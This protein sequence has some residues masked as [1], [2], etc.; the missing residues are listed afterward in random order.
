MVTINGQQV[1][2]SDP[3]TTILQAARQAGIYIP[4][5]CAH[6]DLPP[7]GGRTP[8]DFIYMDGIRQET[9]SHDPVRGC[10]LCLVEADGERKPACK[11]PAASAAEVQT[12]TPAILAARRQNLAGILANHPHACLLCP[13]REGCDRVQCSLNVPAP[14]RCCAK[15]ASC[16]L[17]KVSEHVG[18]Q[19][20]TPR[21]VFAGLPVLRNQP[22]FTKDFN[23]CIHCTRCVRVCDDVRDVRSLAFIALNGRVVVG[24]VGPTLAESGCRFCTACVEVCP[25]GALM[26]RKPEVRGR[27]VA[28]LVTHGGR[29]HAL[30]PCRAACP[31]M[32][33]VPRYV[34]LVAE[35]RPSQAAAVIRERV[36]FPGVLGHVCFHPCE[37][38]CRRGAI[39]EPV[40]VC[41]LKRFAAERDGGVW[42]QRITRRPSTGKR[43][44]IV[45]S[46]PAG[47]TAAYFLARR[48]HAVTVLEAAPE[49]G[50]MLRYGIPEY[51]LPRAVL[52]R[53][54]REIANQGVVIATGTRVGV[55]LSL[56]QVRKSHDAVFVAVGAQLSRRIPVEGADL[57]G[58]L[59]GVDFLREAARRHLQQMGLGRTVVIGGGN[60][61]V[62]AAMTALRCGA[63]DAQIACLEK[64]EE[65]PA[66]DQEIAAMEEEGITIRNSWGP[67]AILG[68]GGGRVTGIE[69]KRC[70]SVFD[71]DHRF[72]P[73]YD[74]ATTTRLEC[75]TVILAI[76]Q[77]SDLTLL[78]G[79]LEPAAGGTIPLLEGET[80]ATGAPG[81]FAGGEAVS[82]PSSVVHAVAAGRK[83]AVEI[84]R[85][86]GGTGCLDEELADG[87]RGSARIG[88]DEGFA[89]RCRVTANR[90][91]AAERLTNFEV[92]D[93]G[94]DNGDAIAEAGRCL[95]C[96]LRLNIQAPLSPPVPWLPLNSD[97]IA[98]VP[99]SDGVYQLLDEARCVLRISGV[100]DL[101]AGLL[102]AQ[103][104][105]GKAK[106]FLY[107]VNRMY[108]QRESELLQHHLQEHGKMPEG[109]DEL[110]DLF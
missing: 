28:P 50:G 59:W 3:A 33:D 52:D 100:P 77:S 87:G 57:G 8:A 16:E 62:D 46:G 68:N 30:V 19:A 7:M 72:H 26:D 18:I 34:R 54:I 91:P 81:V 61:A 99:Q 63:S 66:F 73:S 23:L 85:Y 47:L 70:V 60:V 10:G 36:P 22:L 2:V 67:R 82:G 17:R 97:A 75:E 80:C 92:V 9:A 35:G 43:V 98:G 93:S 48:G 53:E 83:A 86:L 79:T 56:K 78:E 106:Y 13:N 38:G 39:T 104:T 20:D 55:T 24:A 58:V 74:E 103:M 69:L 27:T 105:N 37:D 95:Q 44:A 31:V 94:Y 109:N 32:T 11:T 51:R 40:S 41:R 42:K 84:D 14:E 25:T 1:E 110:G 45:G 21:Y 89:A 65:M 90:Q 96:D 107:E 49:A 76:G 88:R 108:T 6:P 71:Q 101:R 15:F 29:E 102:E 5:L 12:D 64:R 4:T